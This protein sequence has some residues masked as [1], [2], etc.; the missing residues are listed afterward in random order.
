MINMQ[1]KK[2][3]EKSTNFEPCRMYEDKNSIIT[4]QNGSDSFVF[5]SSNYEGL[6]K[7]FSQF[8]VVYV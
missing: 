4:F 5:I 2:K 7:G 6:R 8:S 3:V 1:H